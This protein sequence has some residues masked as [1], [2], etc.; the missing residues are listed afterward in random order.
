MKKDAYY[1]THDSNARNDEKLLAVR[2]KLGWEGY[3]LY[4]AI[5]EKLRDSSDYMCVKDYNLIAFDLRVDAAKVKSIVEEFRLFAFTEDGECFYS[6]SLL[7]RMKHLDGKREKA[8]NAGK[9]SAEKRNNL[10]GRSTDVQQTFNGRSTIKVNESKLNESKEKESKGACAP[11]SPYYAKFDFQFLEDWAKD[12]FRKWLGYKL[13]REEAY[14]TQISIEQVYKKLSE[15][16][17]KNAEL[18]MRIVDNVIEKNAKSLFISDDL[19]DNKP[20]KKEFL[21]PVSTKKAMELW[22]Q[23]QESKT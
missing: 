20:E 22:N 13:A 10:N 4:W 12:S 16:S 3:G 7:Q 19:K 17:G 6:E 18:A 2:M 8:S 11:P 5:I 21:E 23:M 15:L 14:I 9:V 1:F